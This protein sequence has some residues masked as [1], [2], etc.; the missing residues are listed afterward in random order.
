M[1]FKNVVLAITLASSVLLGCPVA[2]AAD[3]QT[4]SSPTG[5]TARLVDGAAIVETEA[6]MSAQDGLFTIRA[7]DQT[8]LAGA[9]L[10]FRI[11]D[12]V[13]PIDAR[14]D[15]HTATLTPHLDLDHAVYTPVAL[16]FEDTADFR[17]PY[18]R[19]Q[20]A[21]N[22]M[23]TTIA[24]GTMVGTL[25]G[26]IGGAAVGCV[27]GAVA[28]G[29]VAAAT[30]VGLFGAFLPAAA[31]GCLGGVLAVGALGAVAGQLLVSAPIAIM[32]AIQY[33][34]TITAPMPDPAR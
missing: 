14:I 8:L 31:A 23:I 20:A 7:P 6:A 22:R 12:F 4:S 18:Q 17:T 9:E 27:L 29:T 13:F 28:A 34:T 1:R 16:P 25:A 15:G 26:S 10:S 24:T 3:D 30:I 11:D 5:F 19:E 21:W 2:A 32:A 33:L